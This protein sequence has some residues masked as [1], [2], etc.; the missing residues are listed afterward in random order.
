MRPEGAAPNASEPRLT[1]SATSKAVS[2]E[3]AQPWR[4]REAPTAKGVVGVP[5]RMG[6]PRGQV[7]SGAT[8]AAAAAPRAP[9][10]VANAVNT[11]IFRLKKKEYD[12]LGGGG[13]C[14]GVQMQMAGLSAGQTR[15]AGLAVNPAV[16]SRTAEIV[17]RKHPRSVSQ[18]VQQACPRASPPQ[19]QVCGSRRAGGRENEK[20]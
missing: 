8:A 4:V 14:R 16:E 12:L 9:S 2:T 17:G 11:S 15:P 20:F 1:Q 6:A 13:G 10:S 18:H 3:G 5:S 19:G 7:L